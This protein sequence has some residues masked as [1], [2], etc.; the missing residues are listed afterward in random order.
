MRSR[1]ARTRPEDLKTRWNQKAVDEI[2]EA[3]EMTAFMSREPQ[4]LDKNQTETG[5][6]VGQDAGAAV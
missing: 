5:A 2:R 6:I 1:E 3:F 4:F